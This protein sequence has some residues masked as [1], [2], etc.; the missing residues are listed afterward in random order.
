MKRF[1]RSNGLDTALYKTIPFFFFSFLHDP[2]ENNA[3]YGPENDDFEVTTYHLTMDIA[4]FQC[5]PSGVNLMEVMDF[6]FQVRTTFVHRDVFC[7]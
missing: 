4:L 3:R 2:F 5:F 1:E 7:E 6:Y